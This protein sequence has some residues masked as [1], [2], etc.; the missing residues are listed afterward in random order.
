[1]LKL[2]GIGFGTLALSLALSATAFAGEIDK[3]TAEAIALKPDLDNGRELYEVCA[4]CHYSEGWGSEDGTMPALSG[5][6]PK[7]TIKQLADIRAKN[8]DTPS[9]YPF[10]LPR[11]IGGPQGLADVAAYIAALKMNPKNGQG[12]W[13]AG[14]AEYAQGEKLYQEN[15]AKCHGEKGEGNDAKYYTRLQS[16]HYNYMLRQ[17]LEIRNGKRKNADPEMVQQI[18]GF[19]EK[20]M[21]L[22]VN[23]ASRLQAPKAD[24]AP[25]ADWKNPDFK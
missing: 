17:F 6:H 1:M 23:F 15:C 19:N 11:S 20:D 10:A 12:T 22:V 21:Q 9:M 3:E 8:R 16:Q 2:R 4:A 24:L 14:T 13:A 7:V 25:S 5:Q 18:K